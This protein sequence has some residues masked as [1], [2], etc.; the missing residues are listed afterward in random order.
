LCP[1]T[2]STTAH[3]FYLQLRNDVYDVPAVN[4][5][6]AAVKKSVVYQIIENELY[7]KHEAFC[8]MN[9]ANS[10]K[11]DAIEESTQVQILKKNAPVPR[12]LCCTYSCT[13]VH[14][15]KQHATMTMDMS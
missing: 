9:H 10:S 13:R 2:R 4:A 8:N 15:V 11:S 12:P 1:Y 6:A 7:G 5:I 3:D 14:T